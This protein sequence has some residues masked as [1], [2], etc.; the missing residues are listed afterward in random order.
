MPDVEFASSGAARIEGMK[1]DGFPG[2]SV[3]LRRRGRRIS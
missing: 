2:G 1:G 3:L